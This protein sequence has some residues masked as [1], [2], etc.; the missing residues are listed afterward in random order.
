M[1]DDFDYEGDDGFMFDDYIYAE[2]SYDL[3]V[4]IRN[5]VSA[6]C[7]LATLHRLIVDAPDR[8]QLTVISGGARE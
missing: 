5:T 7:M 4:S 8:P 1:G 3:A 2:E 6:A